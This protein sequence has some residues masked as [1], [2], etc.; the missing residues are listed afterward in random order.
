MF[1][2]VCH[3]QVNYLNNNVKNKSKYSKQT[4]DK[5][6]S[7]LRINLG[8]GTTILEGFVNIDNSPS[9]F[10]QRIPGLK[11]LLYLLR[12]IDQKKFEREWPKD[13]IFNDALKELKKYPDSSVEEIF[14]SHF[15]EHLP[16]KKAI[17]LLKQCKRVLSS[18]GKLRIV[19]PDLVFH[20][21]YYLET[22]SSAE[23]VAHDRF[24][25][26]VAGAYLVDSR[27]GQNHYY[28][29]DYW[30]LKDLLL[31]IG[32]TKVERL[33]FNKDINPDLYKIRDR[34]EE[35]LCIEASK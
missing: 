16:L 33:D 25:F 18:K 15:L 29:Y 5:T 26:E 9:V 7:P 22:V 12:I 19:V 4:L 1:K 11:N 8:C 10:V 24:L 28:I 20:A 14:S 35:S 23:K 32:F 30:S 3:P 2:Q 6:K 21:K 34:L 31:E 17:L 13:V 27:K